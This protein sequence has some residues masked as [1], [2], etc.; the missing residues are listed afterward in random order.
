MGALEQ[1]LSWDHQ[2]FLQRG[3]LELESGDPDL[4]ENF[5][6][7]AAA[8]QPNDL[9]V[10]T[11]LA[12]LRLKQAVSEPNGVASRELLQ[13]GQ[14]RL[15]TVILTRAR[16]D[17]HQYAIYA[18][19]TLLWSRRSDISRDERD[20]ALADALRLL[21]EGRE[22][23]PSDEMLRALNAEIQT[24]QLGIGWRGAEH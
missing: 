4:A 15:R 23:H 6:N 13:D 10:Q 7:Q 24:E 16:F 11:E 17:A 1:Y 19:Q 20:E 9:L 22:F 21:E 8:M 5:L 18:K 14:Q 12:Y 2:Y 3:S